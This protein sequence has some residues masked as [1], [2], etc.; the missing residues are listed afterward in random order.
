MEIRELRIGNKVQD[1]N[2]FIFDVVSIHEDGTIYCDFE[3]NEGDV[4]EFD[5]KNPCYP[6]PLTEEILLKLGFEKIEEI[7]WYVDY[8]IDEQYKIVYYKDD[9]CFKLFSPIASLSKIKYLHELQNLFFV[10]TGDELEVNL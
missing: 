8:R 7:S 3:G 9:K 6:I 1:A 4:W 10:L 5:D 2:G